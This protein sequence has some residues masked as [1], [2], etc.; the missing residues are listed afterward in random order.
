MR[1]KPSLVEGPLL[2][3]GCVLNTHSEWSTLAQSKKKKI[4]TFAG[5]WGSPA[6]NDQFWQVKMSKITS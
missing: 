4:A 6:K 5:F 1:V 3:L 2:T